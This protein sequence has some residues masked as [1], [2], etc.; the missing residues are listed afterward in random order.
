[1]SFSAACKVVYGAGSV[2]SRELL[3]DEVRPWRSSG[4]DLEGETKILRTQGTK[5]TRLA[6]LNQ[7][8]VHGASQA[9]QRG[10][11][12]KPRRGDGFFLDKRLSSCV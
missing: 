5:S 7:H 11:L 2:A 10:A 1:M 4:E 9:P 8:D 3:A 6:Y 12:K